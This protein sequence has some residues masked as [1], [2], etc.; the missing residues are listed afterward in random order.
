MD[1]DTKDILLRIDQTLAGILKALI[2]NQIKEI[3]SNET[4]SRIYELTGTGKTIG[5]IA[6]KTNVSTGKVSG[7]WKG[8]EESGLIVKSGKSFKKLTERSEIG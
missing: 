6:K 5:E 4:L 3:R 8:W 7:V 1:T 2:A